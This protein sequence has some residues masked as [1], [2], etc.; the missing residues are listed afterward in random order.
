MNKKVCLL[1]TASTLKEA[2]YSDNSME[3]WALGDMFGIVPMDKISRWFEIHSREENERHLVRCINKPH[4]EALKGLKIPVYMQEYYK[5]IPAS[6]PYPLADMADKYRNLFCSTVDYMMALAIDEKYDEVHIYGVNM[7]TNGEYASQRPSL[8]YWLG[9][10]EGRGIKVVLP[11]GCDL[12]KGYFRYG[13]DEVKENDLLVKARTK[14][15]EL[16][17]QS[18]EFMKNYYLSLGAKDTWDFILR[19]MGQ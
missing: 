3:F 5:D 13:Y 7:A 1:G 18:K 11:E 14:S 9:Q 6:V 4:I 15:A 19:E 2:P 12:L 16:D 10:A 17:L 8:Y